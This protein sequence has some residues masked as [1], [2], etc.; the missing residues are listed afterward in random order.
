[1]ELGHLVKLPLTAANHHMPAL[2]AAVY[3]KLDNK[4]GRQLLQKRVNKPRQSLA[5]A[6]ATADKENSGM[7]A[8]SNR[9]SALMEAVCV[10]FEPAGGFFAQ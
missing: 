10:V 2:L 3:D 7:P 9:Q 5:P 4:Y 8:A 1:M 6:K